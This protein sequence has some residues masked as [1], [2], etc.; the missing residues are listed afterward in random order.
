MKTIFITV[1]QGAEAKNILRTDIYTTLIAHKDTR[2]VFFVDSPEKEEYY[3]KEF[4]HPRVV[5]EAVP[6]APARGLD[7]FFS[8]IGFLLL[9]TATTR[10]RRRMSLADDHKY[11]SHGIAELLNM[12]LARPAVRRFVRAMDLVL[13]RNRTFAPY[14]EKYQSSAVLLA[15]LFD[16]HEVQ[17]LREAKRRG[18]PSIGFVNSWDKLT[19]RHSIRLQPDSMVVFNG[20]VKKEAMRYADMDERNI[21]VSGIPQYD[22][23]VNYRPLSRAEFVKKHGLETS[24]KILVYAPM[25]KAFSN[26]DWDIIDMLKTITDTRIRNAQVF[27]RFQPNDFVDE[28]ELARRPWL[29]YEIPGIRF[30]RKRGVNW[31]MSFD[32]I[33]GL[34]DTLANADLFICYASS[35]SVD[36]A[37]FDVPVVNIDFEVKEKERMSKTPTFFY[38][39]AHYGN[40]I[41]TGGIEMPRSERELVAAIAEYLE[42]PEKNREGR[43]RLVKEQCD[44]VDGKAGQR[45]GEYIIMKANA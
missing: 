18:V 26:S 41:R 38:Q 25:G 34:T 4:T 39:T 33:R 28:A 11:V 15:N 36:A 42:H 32:D 40:A 7:R 9:R 29:R 45:I 27:V 2:L 19:A 35:M 20:I 31:D 24:K 37:V 5:Y 43:A 13:V 22:W 17:L 30:S 14:F 23:H 10:L 8:S 44:V 6:P 12:L 3:R 21:F 1:F 16:D